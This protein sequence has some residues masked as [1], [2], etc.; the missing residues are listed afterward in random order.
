MK[1]F[2]TTPKYRG[3]KKNRC[4][5]NFSIEE[6][7]TFWSYI[8]SNRKAHNEKVQK[9]KRVENLNNSYKDNEPKIQRCSI[10]RDNKY[11]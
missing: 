7:K 1:Y 11:I 2:E 3:I 10:W 4:K 9:I 8:W 6:L 5:E